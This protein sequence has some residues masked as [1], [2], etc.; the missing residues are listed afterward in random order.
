MDISNE[1]L[2]D[3]LGD[4]GML[5][6]GITGNGS[7]AKTLDEDHLMRLTNLG[8]DHMTGAAQVSSRRLVSEDLPPDWM[9]TTQVRSNLQGRAV[10]HLE[11]V[12]DHPDVARALGEFHQ[13]AGHRDDLVGDD[14]EL[15]RQLDEDARRGNPYHAASN[16]KFTSANAMAG[17]KGGSFSKRD[18]KKSKSKF[19]G[20]GKNGKPKW[21]RTP[22]VCGR[23]ARKKG[24]NV[25]CH[26]G[27]PAAGNADVTSRGLKSKGHSG[28]KGWRKGRS[29]RSVGRS[30]RRECED[31][32]FGHEMVEDEGKV[33]SMS[34]DDRSAEVFESDAGYAWMVMYFE[35]GAEGD[36]FGEGWSESLED[37]WENAAD[38][39]GVFFEDADPDDDDDDDD[40]DKE[41][42]DE[43]LYPEVSSTPSGLIPALDRLRALV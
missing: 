42:E 41:E 33:W 2:R 19:K 32:E 38:E 18:E 40:D 39:M 36:I 31:I 24:M 11:E 25:L 17:A 21:V 14:L 13:L 9:T 4:E 27:K 23:P 7:Q 43:P 5:S 6:L 12:D 16:G 34:I 37:A 28:G 10:T 15:D 30:I 22:S 8:L 35:E 29:D 3:A 1:A 26:T 20:A